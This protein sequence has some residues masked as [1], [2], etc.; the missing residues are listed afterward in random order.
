MM[1]WRLTTLRVVLTSS[2]RCD[3]TDWDIQSWVGLLVRDDTGSLA[4]VTYLQMWGRLYTE[5]FT[6]GDPLPVLLVLT[7]LG[8]RRGITLITGTN[9]STNLSLNKLVVRQ[10]FS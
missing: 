10:N 8:W 7:G 2:Y 1:K 6:M 3:T 9:S 5:P 4:L